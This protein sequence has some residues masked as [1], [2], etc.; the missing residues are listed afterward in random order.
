MQLYFNREPPDHAQSK[1]HW[2]ILGYLSEKHS[3]DPLYGIYPD[4]NIP[5]T[6]GIDTNL[7]AHL[8]RASTDNPRENTLA[9]VFKPT[10]DPCR[11]IEKSPSPK[12]EGFWG[13]RKTS[14]LG[15]DEFDVFDLQLLSDLDCKLERLR[16]DTHDLSRNT[17]DPTLVQSAVN[18]S[19]RLTSNEVPFAWLHKN[20]D[21]EL[22][23]NLLLRQQRLFEPEPTLVIG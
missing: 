22:E 2:G 7:S 20:C 10:L 12:D 15:L 23:A 19:S 5:Q 3:R 9:L 14:R 17:A 18:Q 6:D 21:V 8:V 1:Y 11:H 4:L 13:G 16:L